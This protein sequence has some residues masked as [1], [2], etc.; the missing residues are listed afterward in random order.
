[1]LL[2]KA[3]RKQLPPL[4]SQETKG[5]DAIAYVKFFTPDSSWTWY[6]TEFDGD[7]LFFG[8]V[9]G[10]VKELGHFRLCELMKVRGGLGLPI[11]RDR[12]WDPTP[13]REIAPEKF[14][15][16]PR[17]ILGKTAGYR[18]K[19]FALYVA[20]QRGGWLKTAAMMR[21]DPSKDTVDGI[22]VRWEGVG[23]TQKLKDLGL[24]DKDI[25]LAIDS[26]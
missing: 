8:L 14:D 9:D 2:T 20:V 22:G 3:N 5:G 1:M 17:T 16:A 11:E 26:L 15:D 21:Y 13:L 25:E 7:D 24:R 10:H 23:T 6:C 12:Y 4:K 19:V 18:E